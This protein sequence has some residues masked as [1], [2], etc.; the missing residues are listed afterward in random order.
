MP[1]ET[2][3]TEPSLVPTPSPATSPAPTNERSEAGRYFERW[4]EF[5]ATSFA[6]GLSWEDTG[7]AYEAHLQARVES[8]S[9]TVAQRDE[10]LAQLSA[11]NAVGTDPVRTAGATDGNPNPVNRLRAALASQLT[12]N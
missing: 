4:G 12:K 11:A 7:R 5:G 2:Q 6:R 10:R 3:T 1:R 8:L 9:S